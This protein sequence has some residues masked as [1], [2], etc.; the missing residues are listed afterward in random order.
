MAVWIKI[1]VFAAFAIPIT[2]IDLK[3]M[4]VPDAL[5]LGGIALILLLDAFVIKESLL[6]LLI[7]TIAGFG[8]F[9]LIHVVTRG[10]LGLGDAKY[11]AFIA[12][13]VGM[14]AWFTTLAI[15]SVTGLA[16]GL[17]LLRLGRVERSTRIPFAPFLTLGATVSIVLG[18]LVPGM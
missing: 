11:S 7:E 15:A 14:Y 5:S 3:E 6:L 4:R 10:K 1:A 18:R 17:I 2:F 8:V 9:W 12:L 16:C 13:C